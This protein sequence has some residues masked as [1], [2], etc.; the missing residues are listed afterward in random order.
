MRKVANVLNL[1]ILE[2]NPVL[3]IFFSVKHIVSQKC[4]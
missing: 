3:F 4:F 1:S 2:Y